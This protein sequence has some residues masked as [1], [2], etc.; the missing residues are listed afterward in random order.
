MRTL[1]LLS[2]LTVTFASACATS[3][4]ID[5]RALKHEQRASYYESRGDFDKAAREREKADERWQK[6]ADRAAFNG[7]RY[8]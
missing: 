5:Q 6:S 3:W 1:L 7:G 2:S 8:Y 4:E